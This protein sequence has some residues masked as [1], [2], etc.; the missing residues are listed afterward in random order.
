M[1]TLAPDEGKVS[2]GQGELVG[3]LDGRLRVQVQQAN[4][5]LARDHRAFKGAINFLIIFMQ[6]DVPFGHRDGWNPF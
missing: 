3:D 2:S 5:P 1:V 4:K 6:E